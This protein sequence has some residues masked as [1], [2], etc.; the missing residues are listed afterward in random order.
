MKVIQDNISDDIDDY[1][2]EDD[3]RSYEI[4]LQEEAKGE[5]I[6]HEDVKWES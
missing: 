1:A 5:L 2:S 6:N 4:A 3:L